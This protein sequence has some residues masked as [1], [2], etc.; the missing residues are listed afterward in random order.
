MT[1][2]RQREK[3]IDGGTTSARVVTR[4]EIPRA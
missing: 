4:D 3:V 1:R 2:E